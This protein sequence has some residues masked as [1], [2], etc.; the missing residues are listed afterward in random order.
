MVNCLS[1]G[2]SFITKFTSKFS[3]TISSRFIF[4]VGILQKHTLLSIYRTMTE[5]TAHW[6]WL[7]KNGNGVEYCRPL[8]TNHNK[9][10]R[11]NL[12]LAVKHNT[13][14]WFTK[15][16]TSLNSKRY[17]PSGILIHRQNSYAP[18]SQRCSGRREA[19][20]REPVNECKNR[21]VRFI[22]N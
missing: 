18:L 22:T 13:V 20:S 8:L 19:Q 10:P 15:L 3:P 2:N 12:M 16:I 17:Q 5:H 11:M 1:T 6:L 9:F 21:P 14:N 7:R 4:H